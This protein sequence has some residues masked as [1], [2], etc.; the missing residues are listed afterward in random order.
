MPMYDAR[1]PKCEIS[2]LEKEIA[3]F[4]FR[5][6]Y[7]GIQGRD[8]PYSLNIN[9]PRPSTVPFT[10]ASRPFPQFVN[11]TQYRLDGSSHFNGLQL[12]AKRRYGSLVVDANYSFQSNLNNYSDLE[13]PYDV[14]SHWTNISQTRRQYAV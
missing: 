2:F 12:E 4:G 13:N 7:I 10:N 9:I 3:H 11:V 8:L 5:A 1:K 14:L 6:S